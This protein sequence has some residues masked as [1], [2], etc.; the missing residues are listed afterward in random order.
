MLVFT[1]AARRLISTFHCISLNKKCAISKMERK[2]KAIFGISKPF[3]K[4][5]NILQPILSNE[6]N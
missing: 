6:G 2:G 4:K 1:G 3:F 5:N